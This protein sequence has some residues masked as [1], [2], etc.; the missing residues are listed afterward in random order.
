[1]QS[2]VPCDLG[3]TL[4]L[5]FVLLVQ[6][7]IYFQVFKKHFLSPLRTECLIQ[8]IAI[9]CS[10]RWL[11]DMVWFCGVPGQTSPLRGVSLL[12]HAFVLRCGRN[13]SYLKGRS[14]CPPSNVLKRC[15]TPTPTLFLLTLLVLAVASWSFSL[16]GVPKG[17][18]ETPAQSLQHFT[19][20]ELHKCWAGT[21]HKYCLCLCGGFWAASFEHKAVWNSL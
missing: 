1:M 6:V 5:S 21:H 19:W 2:F 9:P 15:L 18:L 7:G 14:I 11:C 13:V 10:R 4:S 16:P 8:A 20:E 12:R 17:G 3:V